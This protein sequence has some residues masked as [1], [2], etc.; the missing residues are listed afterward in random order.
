MQIKLVVDAREV[1]LA[2]ETVEALVGSLP[3]EDESLADLLHALAQSSVATVR[4]AVARKKAISEETVAMLA[5]DPSP[6]VTGL[7][8]ILSRANSA[9]RPSSRS[10]SGIG[11][12]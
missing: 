10:F 4:A 12:S 7:S 1:E 8:Y 3:D 9:N 5:S 2:W 11:V 6:E